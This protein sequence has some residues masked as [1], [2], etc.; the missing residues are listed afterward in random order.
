VRDTGFLMEC[1]VEAG[2]VE[3]PL[4]LP[5]V[6]LLGHHEVL[7]VLVIRPDL[8]L[9]FRTLNEMLPPLLEGSDDCQHLLVMDLVVLLD[10]GEGFG[11]ESDQVPLFVLWGHLGEN[12]TCITKNVGLVQWK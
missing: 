11:E 7:Q 3:G 9:M 6:Q 2:E 5:L 10:G 12:S 4:G 1:K 8:T